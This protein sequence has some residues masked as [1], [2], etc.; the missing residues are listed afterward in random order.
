MTHSRLTIHV[1]GNSSPTLDHVHALATQ[2][3]ISLQV[4]CSPAADDHHHRAM[5][6]Q[7]S[8]P[9]PALLLDGDNLALH[10]PPYRPVQCSFDDLDTRSGP[11]RSLKNPLLKAIGVKS[12]QPR[13]HV[14]DATAGLG[15]DSYLLAAAGC[16]VT[17]CERSPALA[18]MLALAV[19]RLGTQ[20]QAVA[21]RMTVLHS[22]SRELLQSDLDAH[23]VYLDP[24][25]SA[26]RKTAPRRAMRVVRELV[27]DDHDAKELLAAAQTQPCRLVVK[28]PRHA[29][30][31][32]KR[33]ADLSFA[34]NAVRYDVYLPNQQPG[35]P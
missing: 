32:A 1:V 7:S 24:M 19:Q 9:R 27:G 20:A 11:G 23:A 17:A 14:F 22:D 15:E 25:Y 33:P 31:L 34:G 26:K 13:P 21:S 8:E 16:Q 30:E 35:E 5:D 2:L 3:R 4:Q 10:R 6:G 28:R 29:P 12:G 18:L